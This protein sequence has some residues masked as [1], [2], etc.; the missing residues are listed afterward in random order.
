MTGVEPEADEAR[1]AGG[2]GRARGGPR[3]QRRRLDSLPDASFDAVLYRL[4]LHHVV[5]QVPLEPVFAEAARL[6]RPG[7]LLVAVE[8]GLWHPVGAGL[9]LANTAGRRP[10]RARH[11][12][13]RAAV[14]AAAARRGA[15]AAGLDAD[16]SA[17]TYTWRRMPAALQ[18]ALWP[19]DRALGTRPRAA[20][21]GHTLMLVARARGHSRA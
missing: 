16:L 5:F 2:R 21:F 3:G 12:R 8:P 7:G 13:R 4:V 1:R 19:V 10:G 20:A 14:A 18:R 17:V 15:R 11:A 6:L 9:A